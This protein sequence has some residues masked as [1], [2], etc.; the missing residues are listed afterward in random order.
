[1]SFTCISRQIF[2]GRFLPFAIFL[3][4]PAFFCHGSYTDRKEFYPKT[5]L[6][7]RRRNPRFCSANSMR[8]PSRFHLRKQLPVNG[9]GVEYLRAAIIKLFPIC[10]AKLHNY[11]QTVDFQMVLLKNFTDISQLAEGSFVMAHLD[12]RRL[13]RFISVDKSFVP[14]TLAGYTKFFEQFPPSANT[15]SCLAR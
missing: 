1:M 13:N 12:G 15:P 5:S 10:I 6:N 3:V 14:A 11:L 9:M 7:P 2:T 8:K 4:L